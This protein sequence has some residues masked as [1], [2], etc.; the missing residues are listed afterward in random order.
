MPPRHVVVYP[1]SRWLDDILFFAPV[2]PVCSRRALLGQT[3]VSATTAVILGG[4][5]YEVSTV[6]DVAR[7]SK[8]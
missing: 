8:E 1:A 3:E 6:L 2:S 5:T 7:N 4:G